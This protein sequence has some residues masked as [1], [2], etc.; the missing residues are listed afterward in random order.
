MTPLTN[1]QA[2]RYALIPGLSADFEKI[3]DEQAP[4]ADPRSVIKIQSTSP[5]THAR[6]MLLVSIMA[7]AMGI[8]GMMATGYHYKFVSL[9][10]GAPLLTVGALYMLY[11][12]TTKIQ[13][14]WNSKLST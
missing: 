7:I 11:E 9:T 6:N 2:F 5:L 1:C 10:M 3:A 12:A 14:V 13:T 8:I 4:F